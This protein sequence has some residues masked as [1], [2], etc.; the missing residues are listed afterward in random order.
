MA[1]KFHIW[2]DKGTMHPVGEKHKKK[3]KKQKR[4]YHN[5]IY[6]EGK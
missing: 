2:P 6:E 4:K 3:S 5:Y 1:K